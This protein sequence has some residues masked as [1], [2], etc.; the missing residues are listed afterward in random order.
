VDIL[1]GETVGVEHLHHVV[2]EG[3]HDIDAVVGGDGT[4]SQQ[5]PAEVTVTEADIETVSPGR[6]KSRVRR[7][8]IR[9][10]SF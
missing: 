6:M 7:N 4:V 8:R 5:H 3:G 1:A 9:L 10:W 2:D